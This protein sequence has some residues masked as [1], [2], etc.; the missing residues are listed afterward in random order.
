MAND[1]LDYQGTHA[2]SSAN[3]RHRACGGVASP[4]AARMSSSPGSARMTAL[5][6]AEIRKTIASIR[7]PGGCAARGDV[8]A[9]IAG[10]QE[11]RPSCRGH[12]PVEGRFGPVPRGD[13]R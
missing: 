13:G 8:Q 4:P 11:V 3:D 5:G 12:M 1:T 10:P 2:S 7:F 9:V 6:R